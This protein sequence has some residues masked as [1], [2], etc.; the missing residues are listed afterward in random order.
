MTE[1]T[2]EF[3]RT[4]VSELLRRV[5]PKVCAGGMQLTRTYKEAVAFAQKQLSSSRASVANLK[6]AYTKLNAYEGSS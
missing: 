6:A 3:W 1:E 4:R 2:P 5:P